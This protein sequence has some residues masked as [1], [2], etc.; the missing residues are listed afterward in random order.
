MNFPAVEIFLERPDAQALDA[1]IGE[2]VTSETE[3]GW[4]AALELDDCADIADKLEAAGLVELAEAIRSTAQD[5]LEDWEK[6]G[7]FNR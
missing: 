5:V 4:K 7:R 6:N 1:A 2:T 3:W